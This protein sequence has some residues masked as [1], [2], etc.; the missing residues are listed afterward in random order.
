MTFKKG[1]QIR[2]EDGDVGQILFIDKD[3]VEAQVALERISIKLRTD[4]LRKFAAEDA[5]APAASPVSTK[6]RA[7][8]ATRARRAPKK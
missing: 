1:D 3:G 6:V 7:A 5:V 8:K 2:T 4:T